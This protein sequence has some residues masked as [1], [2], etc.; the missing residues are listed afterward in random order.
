VVETSPEGSPS[1]SA[2]GSSINSGNSSIPR[3]GESTG[4]TSLDSKFSTNSKGVSHHSSENKKAASKQATAEG[5]SNENVLAPIAE[6][7]SVE[8]P[9][10]I[11]SKLLQAQIHH[12]LTY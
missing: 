11:P 12:L 9:E 8:A 5:G 1:T 2:G 7:E 3:P 4:K 6:V 10:P